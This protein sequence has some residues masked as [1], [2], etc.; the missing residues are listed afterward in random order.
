MAEIFAYTDGACSGNPGPGGWGVVLL[1]REGER[2]LKARELSGGEAMTTNNRMEMTA[3]IAALEALGRPTRVT[4]VTDSAYLR[5]GITRWIHGWKRNGWRTAGQ[6][7]VK[8][9]DLWRRLEAA[10]ARHTVAWEWIK[11]HA[12][13]PENERADALARAGMAP[14]KPTPLLPSAARTPGGR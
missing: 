4:L 14:F 2:V 11:G 7:P 1:A 9:D 5:D 3:A 6:K 10:A 13:H 12:G 8:N